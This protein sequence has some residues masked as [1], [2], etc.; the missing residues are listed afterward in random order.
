MP[1]MPTCL[2]LYMPGD[3][4]YLPPPGL[5]CRG[6]SDI[7]RKTVEILGSLMAGHSSQEEK[8]SGDRG[9]DCRLG[10]VAL[11]TVLLI[12][13]LVLLAAS[14]EAECSWHTLSCRY[15]CPSPN[16][17]NDITNPRLRGCSHLVKKQV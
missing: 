8:I 13:A 17:N 9:A 3:G 11:V 7:V 16:E 12:S 15:V 6:L 1:P 4:Q 14:E 2:S 10:L 5:C